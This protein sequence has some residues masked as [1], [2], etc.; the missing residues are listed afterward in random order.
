MEYSEFTGDVQHRI[1]AAT[2][3]EAVRT[4]RAVLTTL[5]ERLSEDEAADLASP[6]PMEIDWYLLNAESGQRFDWDEFV[7]RVAERADLTEAD[8]VFH[9]KAVVSV[10]DEIEPP[11]ERRD[12]RGSLP[13]DYGDLFK[14]ADAEH[15]PWAE[16]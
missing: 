16:A 15:P 11:G 8:A 1:G 7:S 3:G 6:L 4:I 9:V 10:I 12:V 2:Q 5:G 14:F 13:A